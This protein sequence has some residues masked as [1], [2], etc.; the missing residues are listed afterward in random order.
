MASEKVI[1]PLV[2]QPS[3]ASQ[4]ASTNTAVSTVFTADVVDFNFLPEKYAAE[5]QL[6]HAEFTLNIQSDWQK[7]IDDWFKATAALGTDTYPDSTGAPSQNTVLAGLEAA[8][9]AAQT[10]KYTQEVG[11]TAMIGLSV[12]S[13]APVS[14]DD[15]RNGLKQCLF[16]I[17]KDANWFEGT[18][19]SADG[20]EACVTLQGIF[21]TILDGLAGA[22]TSVNRLLSIDQNKIKEDMQKNTD[23]GA[24]DSHRYTEIPDKPTTT[25][26]VRQLVNAYAFVP[27][28]NRLIAGGNFTAGDVADGL[29]S[30][31]GNP[32]D[33][34]RHFDTGISDPSEGLALDV[35]VDKIHADSKLVFP[36]RI[37]FSDDSQVLDEGT[38]GAASGNGFEHV[39]GVGTTQTID[40]QLNLVFAK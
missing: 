31:D 38:P 24:T 15:A 23:S 35:S 26:R 20:T 3:S 10:T 9:I 25:S 39:V 30:G 8:L 32:V 29:D 17:L 4:S 14:E 18:A 37:I 19:A 13:P 21:T 11:S 33:H 40:F 16:Q 22:S 12:A 1:Q 2:P 28:M 36:V 7:S 6:I 5:Q 27:V 34:V